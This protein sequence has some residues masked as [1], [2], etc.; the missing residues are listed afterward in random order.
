VKKLSI[1]ISLLLIVAML[2][3]CAPAANSDAAVETAAGGNAVN[4]GTNNLK[5]ISISS[6]AGETVVTLSLISGSRNSEIPESKLLSLPEYAVEQ[7]SSPNRIMITIQGVIFWDYEQKASLVFSD[8]LLGL[9]QEAPAANDSLILYLQLSCPAKFTV[10]ESEGNLI[11]RLKPSPAETKKHYYCVSNS[12]FEHQE[13]TWPQSIA[14]TPVLCS[15]LKNKLL[16]SQPFDTAEEAESYQNSVSATLQSALPGNSLSVIEL[17]DGALPDY[18]DIDFSAAENTVVMMKDGSAVATMLLLQNGRY[19][20][21]AP[22]GRIAFARIYRPDEAALRQD[23]YLSGD[24]LWILDTSGRVQ[25]VDIPEFY[26]IVSAGFSFDSRYIC[27]LDA[28]IDNSVAYVYDFTT[29]T[30]WNLG[31]EGFGNQTSAFVWS[32]TGDTLYAM[33]GS[34]DTL[35]MHYCTFNEDGTHSIEAV[36]EEPGAAGCLG[37]SQGRLYYSDSYAGMIY[38]S[39]GETHTAITSGMD[40]KISPDGTSMAVLETNLA[41]G[42][43]VL[44]NLKLYDLT[45]GES[46]IIAENADIAAFAFSPTG[47]TLFYTDSSVADEAE[48]GYPYGL[49]ACDTISGEKKLLAMSSTGDIAVGLSGAIYLIQYFSDAQNSFYATYQY[50]LK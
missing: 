17:M 50:D 1:V 11:I 9:F 43:Q 34:G 18:T 24:K 30:L 32:D 15:D 16:I 29:K 46:S 23:E 3:G 28:S 35:Q 41:D 48:A 27:L 4:A 25:S 39:N 45:T 26:S 42:E 19:L 22:S 12:F 10:E 20:A 5:D 7:L 47:N 37:I 13:G 40:F 44:T 36:E 49:F 38:E 33:A 14:M 2:F 21:T 6:N 31:E 8:F